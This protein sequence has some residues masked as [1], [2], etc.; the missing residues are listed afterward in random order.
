MSV[1]FSSIPVHMPFRFVD[2]PTIYIKR[3]D[4]NYSTPLGF[5]GG[6]WVIEDKSTLVEEEK[7]VLHSHTFDGLTDWE[8]KV[9]RETIYHS[10][11]FSEGDKAILKFEYS[12]RDM[13]F[14]D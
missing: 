8:I 11:R 1:P 12:K 5:D 4:G 13:E 2:R 14:I 9:A 3:G 6:P 10:D 7:G